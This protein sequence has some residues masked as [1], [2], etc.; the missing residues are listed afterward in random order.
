MSFLYEIKKALEEY[1]TNT[2]DIYDFMN[3]ITWIRITHTKS[4]PHKEYKISKIIDEII[5]LN[6]K[7]RSENSNKLREN[8]ELI[9]NIPDLSYYE[10]LKIKKTLVNLKN[11]SYYNDEYD[12]NEKI[13]NYINL[14]D[15]SLQNIYK[16]KY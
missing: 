11:E 1:K 10:Y 16:Q 12:N 7:V 4:R 2:I 9:E 14:L 15:V 13:K 5:E 3:K 8:I 6:R